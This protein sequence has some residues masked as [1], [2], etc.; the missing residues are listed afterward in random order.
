MGIDKFEELL[1]NKGM[2]DSIMLQDEYG[3][4]TS[5]MFIERGYNNQIDSYCQE[6]GQVRTFA[7]EFCEIRNRFNNNVIRVY[8]NK[9]KCNFVGENGFFEIYGN[10]L[11][12]SLIYSCTRDI[13]HKMYFSLLIDG[14]KLIKIGQY[15]S[16]ADISSVE[17]KKYKSVLGKQ[18]AEYS[19]A[20]GLFSHGIG[21]GSFVY[22]RRI[23]E[24]LV[25]EK[26][27]EHKCDMNI[28]EDEFNRKHFDE[29]ILLLA[30]Y[31]PKTLVEHR[32]IYGIVS[33]GIHELSEDECREM[34]PMLQVGI[35]LILD[36][37]LEEKERKLKVSKLSKFVSDKTAQFKAK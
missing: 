10:D 8:R 17:L 32:G 23:I 19:K 35:E 26:Y 11:T 36:D 14:E 2:Y 25:L 24:N 34:F 6:C 20:I 18:Y 22:L 37:M 30:D 28:L 4:I 21:V 7:L 27:G 13:G 3:V 15:P 33:K 16:V 9:N 12:I 5:R 29:K 31:L 1:V